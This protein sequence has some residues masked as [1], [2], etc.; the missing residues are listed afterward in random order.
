M[1]SRAMA[2]VRQLGKATGFF[3]SGKIQNFERKKSEPNILGVAS[4]CQN[5]RLR[6]KPITVQITPTFQGMIR[7]SKPFKQLKLQRK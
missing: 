4:I 2:D 7:I 1:K 3:G 5:L 6:A